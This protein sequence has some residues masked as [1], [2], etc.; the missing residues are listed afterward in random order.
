MSFGLA[1]IISAPLSS[2][3]YGLG[4]MTR[5]R[6]YLYRFFGNPPLLHSGACGVRATCMGLSLT[7]MVV[8][9]ATPTLKQRHSP[10]CSFLVSF[11]REL[12]GGP[13]YVSWA[14]PPS[15]TEKQPGRRPQETSTKRCLLSCGVVLFACRSRF[16]GFS[17]SG[18]VFWVFG[19]LSG[20]VV[21]ISRERLQSFF[22]GETN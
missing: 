11:P 16:L 20:R 9:R 21:P 3:H 7:Q 1:P 13:A 6:F 4:Y 15:T 17:F 14:L 19:F 5:C 2:T 22:Q 8:R 18:F 10:L 12:C